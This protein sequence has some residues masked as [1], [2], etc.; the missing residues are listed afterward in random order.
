LFTGV[1]A[2]L[3]ASFFLAAAAFRTRRAGTDS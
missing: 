1:L 2:V 3:L